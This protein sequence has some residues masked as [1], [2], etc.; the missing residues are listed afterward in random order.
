MSNKPV[1]WMN[2][3]D[4]SLSFKNHCGGWQPLYT[5]ADTITYKDLHQMVKNVLAHPAKEQ[6]LLAE[7]DML[8]KELAILREAIEKWT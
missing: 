4:S 3:D 6:E 1:A 8:K 5:P 2:K 7:I